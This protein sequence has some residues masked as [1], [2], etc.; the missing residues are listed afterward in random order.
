M[1]EKRYI[2]LEDLD[3]YKL[4]VELSDLGWEI[5]GT[6]SWQEKKTAMGASITLIGINLITMPAGLFLKQSTG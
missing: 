1:E 5:Y 4:A 2:K 3:T 6:L